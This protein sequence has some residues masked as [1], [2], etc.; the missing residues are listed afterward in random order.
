MRTRIYFGFAIRATAGIDGNG[1]KDTCVALGGHLKQ[2]GD[3]LSEGLMGKSS[4]G[5]LNSEHA[6]NRDLDWLRN[7]DFAVFETSVP[8]IGVGYEVR[9]AEVWNIPVLCLHRNQD[10]KRLSAMIEGNP[11]PTIVKYDTLDQARAAIDLFF[12]RAL[13][14]T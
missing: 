6:Y 13:R 14:K 7:S 12:G 5:D 10:G 4:S 9:D 8:S 11:N 3:V 2:Y 1:Q